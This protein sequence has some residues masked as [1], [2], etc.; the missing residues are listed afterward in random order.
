MVVTTTNSKGVATTIS[1]TAMS[2]GSASATSS[3]A[4]TQSTNAASG[5]DKLVGGG[6]VLGLVGAV[7]AA[8]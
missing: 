7:M 1:T 6:L 2:T 3:S 4:Q 8:L 5:K